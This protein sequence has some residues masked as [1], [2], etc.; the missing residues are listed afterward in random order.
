MKVRGRFWVSVWLVFFFGVLVIVAARQTS[1]VV[2][3][4][5]LRTLQEER[6]VLQSTRNDLLRRI[7]L[8]RSR[9]RLIPRAESLG[10]RLPADTEVVNIVV[11]SESALTD[12]RT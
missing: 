1:S 6:R 9:E 4:T 3:A 8:S 2:A 5:E 7:S 12:G 11:D 10:L